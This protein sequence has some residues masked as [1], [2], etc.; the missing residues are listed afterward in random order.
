MFSSLKRS[1]QRL[2]LHISKPLDPGFHLSGRRGQLLH[3]LLAE[4]DKS[5]VMTEFSRQDLDAETAPVLARVIRKLRRH[6]EQHAGYADDIM[7]GVYACVR[8][9]DII[10]IHGTEVSCAICNRGVSHQVCRHHA[11]PGLSAF[12]VS[13]HVFGTQIPGFPASSFDV[14]DCVCVCLCVWLRLRESPSLPPSIPPYLFL[15]LARSR[16]FSLF[17]SLSPPL[18]L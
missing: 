17:L 7:C 2:I 11:I 4:A 15:S 10:L 13:R 18:W 3:R 5:G 1:L 16:S 12:A 9:A 6:G 14:R 8:Y